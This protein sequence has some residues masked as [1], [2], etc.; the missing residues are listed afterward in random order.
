MP[1]FFFFPCYLGHQV[2]VALGRVDVDVGGIEVGQTRHLAVAVAAD[3]LAALL[4]AVCGQG[5][6]ERLEAGAG[7]VHVLQERLIGTGRRR[8]QLLVQVGDP[9]SGGLQ[10]IGRGE[11]REQ[12]VLLHVVVEDDGLLAEWTAALATE[13]RVP[14]GHG[15]GTS[16][17][18]TR[19]SD[20]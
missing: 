11:E 3:G 5:R 19:I 9:E 2:V 12:T 13:R 16:E 18:L 20:L 1:F 4:H 10:G 7:G 6:A 8:L 15:H 17:A 14:D